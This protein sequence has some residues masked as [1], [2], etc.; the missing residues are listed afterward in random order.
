MTGSPRS[1]VTTAELAGLVREGGAVVVD[2]RS[3]DA[4]NGWPL[5]R[6]ARGGHV[7]GARSLPAKW[8]DYLDWIEIVRNKGITPDDEIV[9][10]GDDDAIARV[11]DRFAGSGFERVAAYRNFVDEWSADHAL[12]MDQLARW[13]HLVPPSWLRDR[14]DEGA[15]AEGEVV[16]LHAHYRNAD[17]FA[18]GHVP[19]ALPIDT[20]ALE[21]TETWNRRPFH[22]IAGV[23]GELGITAD[24]TVVLYGRCSHPRPDDPFPGSSAGHIAAFR[25]A[26]ILLWAGVRDVRVLDGGLQSWLDEGFEITT[27]ASP[28]P[29]PRRFGRSTPGRP[30]LAV[31]L[32]EAR[33]ILASDRADLVCVRSRPEYLGQVSGY[34]Y[35]DAKGRIPRAVFGHCGSDAY[36]ME[37]YRNLDHTTREFHEVEATWKSAGLGPDRRTAFYCGTGWRGSEAFFN[38]WF[39]GWPD[40]AVFDG[41]WFEWSSDPS[42]PVE[43]GEPV[44]V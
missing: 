4:Y 21:S 15:V 38:A 36:H 16:V 9:L 28:A 11:A 44:E 6:E 24:S 37:N 8:C 1:Q 20:N 2:V 30:R 34:S 33:E 12:P 7:R 23:L 40:A 35:I 22:E 17:D 3:P 25:C 18:R 41:G 14:I 27:E 42:N 43:T 32:D 13:R 5:G 26:W 29:T 39:Q 10:Y 19:G 31:D